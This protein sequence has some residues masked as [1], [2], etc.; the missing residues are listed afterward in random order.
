[1]P[2]QLIQVAEIGPL[3]PSYGLGC[4]TTS[5]TRGLCVL[6]AL[7]NKKYSKKIKLNQAIITSFFDKSK[8]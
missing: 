5:Y 8:K 2:N 4:G 3:N 1:M 6:H 7:L